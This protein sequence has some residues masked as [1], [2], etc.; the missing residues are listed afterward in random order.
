MRVM[1]QEWNE[2][3]GWFL[4]ALKYRASPPKKN[5]EK[6]IDRPFKP[7]NPVEDENP[8]KYMSADFDPMEY[9]GLN[10]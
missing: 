6:P 1:R 9:F 5:G 10:D 2:K 4:P 3:R 8:G 7:D